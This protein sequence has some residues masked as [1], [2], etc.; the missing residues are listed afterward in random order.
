MAALLHRI[1]NAGPTNKPQQ[2][3]KSKA[4]VF[5]LDR[6]AQRL[7]VL[8]RRVGDGEKG[9]MGYGPSLVVPLNQDFLQLDPADPRMGKVGSVGFVGAAAAAAAPSPQIH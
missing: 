3:R 5:A 7:A 6:D 1:A 4:K 9:G 8:K 2:Q